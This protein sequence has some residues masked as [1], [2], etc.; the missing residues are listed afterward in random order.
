MV[1]MSCE[2]TLAER[3]ADAVGE[4]W[5]GEFLLV[6]EAIPASDTVGSWRFCLETTDGETVLDVREKEFADPNRL[7]LL[8][9]V[10]GLEAIEG[11]GCVTLV[12]TSRY[13]IRGLRDSLHR[14]RENGFVWEHFGR[15]APIENADLWRRVD[16][17]LAFHQVN[18]CLLSATR[19]SRNPQAPDIAESNSG[20]VAWDGSSESVSSAA[21]GRKSGD[22]LR[23][24]LFA[25]CSAGPQAPRRRYGPADLALA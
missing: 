23:R 7:A 12:S 16:R 25:Q 19:V 10:R 22:R 11:A 15:M 20:R 3:Q 6:C 5:S 18:A 24:W 4:T 9:V 21:S 14:W 8:S 17:A 2:E 13:V 1:A